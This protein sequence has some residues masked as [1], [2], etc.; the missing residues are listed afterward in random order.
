MPLRV[1]W[2]RGSRTRP[3]PGIA[4]IRFS[5]M[6]R[7][8][9]LLRSP[10]TDGETRAKWV[11]RMADCRRRLIRGLVVLG[12]AWLAVF[13]GALASAGSA[14]AV[15]APGTFTD[16]GTD[17]GTPKALSATDEVFGDTASGATGS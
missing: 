10:A 8:I 15:Q 4:V 3:R 6:I 2:S 17:L 13:S 9:Y 14:A 12:A 16:L 7:G 5:L 11:G 1:H